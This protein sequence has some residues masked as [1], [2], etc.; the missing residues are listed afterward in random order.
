MGVRKVFLIDGTAYCY[1]AFHALPSL[2][3]ADGRPTNAVYGFIMMLQ[4]LREK[5]R[6]EY[7]GV[8]FDVG[9]P[10]FRHQQYRDYKIHRKPMPE[11]LI[12][13]LPLIKSLLSAYRVAVFEREGY[14]GEDVLATIARRVADTQIEV[15]LV[16]ADKDALQLVNSH[17]KVYNPHR[18][19]HVLDAHAVRQRYGVRPTQMVD[20]MALMGDETDN[21]PGVAGIG[22]K[23][24]ARLLQRFGNLE[25]LYAHLDD[26]E[27]PVQRERLAVAQ[28]TAALSQALAR[29]DSEVPLEVT[30][31]DL[32]V[33]EPDWEALRTLFRD[34]EFKRLVAA[35]DAERPSAPRRAVAVHRLR[36]DSEL[37]RLLRRLTAATTPVALTGPPPGV[38]PG[39]SITL[40]IA[41]S[42]E[43]AWVVL[44]EGERLNRPAG[45]RLAA[46]LADPSAQ[47]IGHDL[48]SVS[49]ALWGRGVIHGIV[50]DTLVAAYLLNPSRT[51]QQ[52]SEL[53]EEYLDER[54]APPPNK[55]A[56]QPSR[57]LVGG[58]ETAETLQACGQQAC[59]VLR[60]HERLLPLVRDHELET[61][62][63]EVELPLI[64][65]LAE[66]ERTGIAVDLPFL[67]QLGRS[68][69]AQLA[70]I[71]KE[72]YQ[73]AG[74]TFNLNSPKQ[75]A[76]VLFERLGLPIIKRT[77]TGPST[78]A[79]VLRQLA[80]QHP[81]PRRLLE[82]RE[83]SKLIFTYVEA[84][85][86]LASA[87]RIHT[88]FNQTATATGRL[89]SSDPNLQNIPIKTEL[90][91]QIRKAFV[92]GSRNG[93]LI[94]VDYSQIEL[95]IL[96]HLSMDPTLTDAFRRR[97]DIH[98]FS[99]SLIYGLPES[100][101][102]PEQRQAMKAINYGILYGMS[103]YGLAKELGIAHEEAQSF[104]DAY[105]ER[106]QQVRSYLDGQIA[107]AQTSGFVQTLL[108]RRRWI[109]EL[110]SADPVVR[111]FGERMAVN[112]PIQGSAADLMKRA[113]LEVS[114]QLHTARLASR[115][116]LQVHDE[117]V[118]EAPGDERQAVIDL[119]RPIMEGVFP[120]RVP[121]TV[122]VKV[123][124]NWLDLQEIADSG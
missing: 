45:R 26:V 3:T 103:A 50:G 71:T 47:I 77:K 17:I 121:L 42:P 21:I 7:L 49:R 18:E 100:E 19:G 55:P 111:Q 69:D 11:A 112:T 116:V 9:K 41:V 81:L 83:L 80:D 14:E 82:Y 90:G 75:L 86:K 124:P 62:Y 1:R 2:A 64:A 84:L 88:S 34:L 5:E 110:R 74:E 79:E 27:S 113:M 66:M 106:Y 59:S 51:T 102:Q 97:R 120:L 37:D 78:D 118:F 98:R 33:R 56:D 22:E 57:D 8:A 40:T 89:S 20:L 108:G 28:E 32:A 36:S 73:L 10:T 6:P 12:T 91:R 101:V 92:P 70:R 65:V 123:G 38:T 16:T 61:L 4:S 58:L 72:L 52:L 46:W 107:Q 76:H 93:L 43:E 109:P 87:G 13:Q 104:I 67:A 48:K 95:R 15:L 44:L 23:T 96:A 24:A 85:P 63:R 29:I 94:A 39:A 117:L 122:T 114:R 60:L 68:M 119:V 115:M 25:A 53:V 99:A 31:Q 105:F 30:L 35:L 54:L